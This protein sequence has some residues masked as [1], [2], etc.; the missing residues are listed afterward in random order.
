VDFGS[1]RELTNS[2]H[3][4]IH[5]VAS[6]ASAAVQSAAPRSTKSLIRNCPMSP[7]NGNQWPGM[8]T[9]GVVIRKLTVIRNVAVAPTLPENDILAESGR[10]DISMATST[11][12]TPIRFDTS[13]WLIT[14]YIQ[15]IKGL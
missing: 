3:A 5:G 9:P 12:I 7:G 6:K 11:S 4:R 13:C 1:E 14:E 15:G 10:S 2:F 8:K